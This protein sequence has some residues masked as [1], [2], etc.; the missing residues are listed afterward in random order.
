M[1]KFLLLI[2]LIISGVGLNAQYVGDETIIDYEGYSLG[3]TI[4][5]VEPAECA[6][7]CS[8]QPTTEV[9]ITIP[10]TVEIG[11]VEYSVTSIGYS[12]FYD[13]SSLTSIEIPAGVTQIGSEAFVGCSRMT[14]VAFGENSQL[15]SIGERAFSDCST[16][17]GINIPKD[18]TSIG[19]DAFDGCTALKAIAVDAENTVYD[20]RDNCNALIKTSENKLIKGC[21]NTVIPA[22]VTS[23]ANKAFINCQRLKSIEIP[24]GVTQIGES[25]FHNCSGLTSVTFGENSQLTLIDN[26]TFNNCSSLTSIEIPAGVTQIGGGAFYFC[27]NLTSITFGENSQLTSISHKTFY[28]C[29]NLTSIEIPAGVTQIGICAFTRCSSLTSIEIPASVTQIGQ[30]NF[31][32]CSSLRSI[33]L[34]AESVVSVG[35]Y[36]GNS[37]GGDWGQFQIQVPENLI[38]S[39]KETYPWSDHTITKIYPYHY[40]EYVVK[41]YDGYSLRFTANPLYE[42]AEVSCEVQPTE[43]TAIT[44]PSTIEIND[45]EFNVTAISNSAFYNCQN[46]TSIEIPAGVTQIGSEAFVGC[47]R[48]TNVAFGENSQLTSIGE[49]A[50]SDCS[51]LLGINIPKDV[52]SI[53]EDAF[54]G[55]T[56]L[57]AIAVDAENTVYDSRDNC[58]ALIKTSENK[59]IKGCYNTVI[60][61]TVTSI[62]NKAFINC[63]RLKSIEIPAGVTQIGESA[64]HN[65]SGLTSVTFGEN[66]Q[67][68]LIDNNT[69]NNCSS[70]TSIEIPAGV[71]QI[72]GRAFAGCGLSSITFEENSQLK[73]IGNSAF[74][75]CSIINSIVIPSGVTSI[76]SSAFDFCYSLSFVDIPSSLN[77]I[78]NNAFHECPIRYMICRVETPITLTSVPGSNPDLTVFVPANSVDDY[79]EADTWNEYEILPID[80]A[81]VAITLNHEDGGTVTGA[82][83]YCKSMEITVTATPNK[84]YD[85]IGWKEDGDIVSNDSWYQFV[86]NYN[87]NLEAI[88][89]LSKY[90]N[91]DIYLY[92]N[93]MNIVAEVKVD[94][95]LQNSTLLEVGAFCGDE[96]RGSGRIQYYPEIEKYL[97]MLSVTGETGD[98]IKFKLHDHE[99]DEEMSHVS[100]SILPFVVNGVEGTP[101]EPYSL[102]FSSTA[103][104]NVIINPEDA[105]SVTGAG[106]YKVETY[107]TLKAISNF[108][109]LFDNWTIN[110]EEV[111]S[112]ST[113][114]FCAT[115]SVTIKANFTSSQRTELKRGWNW[116]SFHTF[117]YGYNGLLALELSLGE[118]GLHIKNQ[119]SFVTNYSG[120]WYGSLNSV[121]VEQ[122]YMIR[123]SEDFTL[124]LN[125]LVVDPQ[126]YPITLSKNWEW[127][128]YPVNVEMPL[129][130]ALSGITPSNNDIIKTQGEFA[131]YTEGIGWSGTLEKMKPGKGY[132]YFNNSNSNKY[133]VYPKPSSKESRADNTLN[134]EL[135]W[136]ADHTMYPNNMNMIAVLNVDRSELKE[137]YEIAA[138]DGSELR[139]SARPIYI[140]SLDRHIVFLTVSGDENDNLTLKYYNV[141]TEEEFVISENMIF[142]TNTIIGSVEEPY[143]LNC[144]INSCGDTDGVKL[145]P[146]PVTTNSEINLGVTCTTVE[147]YN[148]LG[149]MIAKYDNIDKLI[150]IETSG[151]YMI[152]TVVDNEVKYHKLIVK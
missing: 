36:E 11:E 84:G 118:Y 110:G 73:T 138:F 17:L 120:S 67:L 51:T 95:V 13:C 2:A 66:S 56:A 148:S 3:F 117:I 128:G 129:A 26:N 131:T 80:P 103:R 137:N 146:N 136:T 12:A 85:F 109:Y 149:A 64:F 152:K 41:E 114:T 123:V 98:N 90:W 144:N 14:N 93:T 121:N 145:Y 35:D 116:T 21:Y 113:Y 108:P 63:Q 105:G 16:L 150:S 10:S 91:P 5:S 71:T 32:G 134:E 132:M 133:L 1:R 87:R 23:I 6:V 49:R 97:L 46:L 130:E 141:D 126:H 104:I 89:E 75:N 151:I 122:M 76:G 59:L 8:T 48:M 82:G 19:E 70:L 15:T 127:I 43:P 142:N 100:L 147:V 135:H 125:G 65:C 111:S 31:D 140:E 9:S 60:P 58:N 22:T 53:G 39:Y 29:S 139:G 68:T 37:L 52:T 106:E 94:D 33:R 50:F 57:K 7:Y 74:W 99:A 124:V 55:C 38:E 115:E 83:N 18:V 34:L 4:T 20:S 81:S 96:L 112:L 101:S 45:L 86:I 77:Y 25:A 54:D 24:A 27:K 72:G 28:F 79:K 62:A 92:P 47:S 30:Y 69:F 40:G 42:G 61:A 107:V 143:V 44:I 102:E 78:E 88:F 119:N